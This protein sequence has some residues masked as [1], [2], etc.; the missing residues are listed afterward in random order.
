MRD[1]RLAALIK[2]VESRFPGVEVMVEHWSD[3]DGDRRIRWW[4]EILH[5]REDD[6][7]AVSRFAHH[8][9]AELYGDAGLPFEVG[10]KDAEGTAAY[11]ARRKA[12]A[13]RD[14][15]LARARKGETPTRR[16]RR[17]RSARA[18]RS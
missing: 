5:V 13:L 2:A 9:G 15:R 14:A 18:G 12:E 3:P 16:T 7:S 4:L 11:L 10:V 8:L 17:R 6:L 1:V